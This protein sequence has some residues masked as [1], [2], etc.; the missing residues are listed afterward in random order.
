MMSNNKSEY[1]QLEEFIFNSEVQSTL[2]KINDHVMDFNIIEITGMGT[3][4]IKH[5]NML[6]WLFG[7][8]EHGLGY[9]IFQKFLTKVINQTRN[10]DFK[11]YLYLPKA[12]RELTIYREKDNIDLLLIDTPNNKVIVIENKIYANERVDGIDGGQLNKYE[13]IISKDFKDYDKY[14][15]Y[16][17]IDESEP[18]EENNETWMVA[19]YQMISD[20]ISEI[21]SS[22]KGL[23]DKTKIVLESYLDLLKRRSIVENTE[24]KELCEKIWKNH[25]DALLILNQYQPDV[26]DLLTDLQIYL[27]NSNIDIRAY[28]K[29]NTDF[30]IISQNYKN[31]YNNLEDYD[32]A[33]IRF[34]FY[35]V[36][37][38]QQFW[39]RLADKPSKESLQYFDKIKKALVDKKLISS[40]VKKRIDIYAENIID[41]FDRFDMESSKEEIITKFDEIMNIVDGCF[42]S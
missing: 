11:H 30:Q 5:S 21:I 20:S 36:K 37:S 16:L 42:K 17:T 33:D 29:S 23:S 35:I 10:S 31:K 40:R 18:S 25:K 13:T 12:Q 39:V 15:I 41:D 2:S 27:K 6:S 26:S 24:L 14:F 8:N 32:E 28:N 38:S 9:L 34:G 1:E 22:Q 4:E 19:S 7:N 3:Q